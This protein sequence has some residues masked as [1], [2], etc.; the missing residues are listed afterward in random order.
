[1]LRLM[2]MLPP[3]SQ[4]EEMC[5]TET[6]P[7][8]VVLVIVQLLSVTPYNYHLVDDRYY[9]MLYSEG[10][11]SFALHKVFHYIFCSCCGVIM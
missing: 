4:P 1:M 10:K 9:V 8:F 3:L 2:S 11:R 5:T 6:S 7:V